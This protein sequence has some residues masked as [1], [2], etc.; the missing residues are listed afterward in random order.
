MA[1]DGLDRPVKTFVATIIIEEGFADL[2]FRFKLIV[3]ISGFIE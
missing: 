3:D 1:L 2:N